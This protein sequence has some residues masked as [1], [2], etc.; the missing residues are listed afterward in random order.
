MSS[1]QSEGR[2]HNGAEP[3]G[4]PDGSTSSA[5]VEKTGRRETTTAGPDGPDAGKVGETFKRT[6]G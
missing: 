3:G 2:K 6:G 1:Q 4:K 5:D